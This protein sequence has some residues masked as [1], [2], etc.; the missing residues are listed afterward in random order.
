[1]KEF[2]FCYSESLSDSL[3]DSINV[4]KLEI[5]SPPLFILILQI[6]LATDTLLLER[7]SS[8]IFFFRSSAS[9]NHFNLH[10]L[11]VEV[12]LSEEEEEMLL[13]LKAL[14]I[15]YFFYMPGFYILIYFD[16][17]YSF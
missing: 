15:D 8:F 12:S 2:F 11:Y 17:L 5:K 6:C 9:S 3:P 13:S 1:M 10:S 14:Y 16:V 7:T 4:C